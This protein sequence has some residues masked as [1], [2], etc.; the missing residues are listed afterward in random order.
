MKTAAAAGNASYLEP[1]FGLLD[2]VGFR[3]SSSYEERERTLEHRVVRGDQRFAEHATSGQGV[4]W[5]CSHAGFLVRA[6]AR[7]DAIDVAAVRAE[8]SVAEMDELGVYKVHAGE[9]DDEKFAVVL[10]DLRGLA[11]WYHQ[12]VGAGLDAMVILC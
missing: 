7:I 12:L 4:H 2:P 5:R 11:R 6:V 10:A 9:D 8:F 3:R 1:P